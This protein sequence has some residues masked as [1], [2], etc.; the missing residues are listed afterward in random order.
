MA[1]PEKCKR[2]CAMPRTNFFFSSEDMTGSGKSADDS[3]KSRNN[4]VEITLSLEEY[5]TIRLIDYSG[6]N[7]EQC[8]SQMHVARTTVQ[9]I[10]TEARKKIS[11]FIV[12]GCSLRI[13]GGN[14]ELCKKISCP[15]FS[16]GCS[17]DFTLSG[18]GQ[19]P[20]NPPSDM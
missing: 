16:G 11:Q 6:L 3:E 9:R 15:R 18:C 14:Y 19:C 13:C 12:D 1:R 4:D 17:G 20:Q 5:E 10:Y 2:I 7:Q 8:A